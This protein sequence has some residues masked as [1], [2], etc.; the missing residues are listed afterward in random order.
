MQP[1]PRLA[2]IDIWKLLSAP[3]SS[4]PLREKADL[5]VLPTYPSRLL[6]ALSAWVTVDDCN[7]S[8]QYCVATDC[9]MA[10]LG[11]VV[12]KD[13]TKANGEATA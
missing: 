13:I 1:W 4:L 8:G 12:K 11:K 10:T 5:T 3:S 2:S 6:P 9:D 7:S